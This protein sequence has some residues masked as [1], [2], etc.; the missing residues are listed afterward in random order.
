MGS[1]LRFVKYHGL[2][3]DFIVLERPE[4]PTPEEARRL[5]ARG[6]SIGAD[7]VMVASPPRVPGA[8]VAMDLVNSDGSSP[9]MCGNGIRCFVKYVVDRLG[10]R[11]N[12]CL[13][14]TPAGIRACAWTAGP[15]G[16]VASVRVEMGPARFAPVEI[17][18]AP[19][20]GAL[21]G[22]LLTLSLD[23]EA[24]TGTPVNTGNPHFVV[25]GSAARDLALRV[26]P[27]LEV[28]PAFPERANIEL[29]EVRS[30]E[31]VAVTVWERGCGLTW[32][33]GTGATAT[34]AAAVRRG[35]VPAGGRVRVTLPGGDLVITIAPDFSAAWMEGPATEVFVGELP[36]S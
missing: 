34:V 13:V 8:H 29:A 7:G 28:H 24:F 17:P 19:A 33:C 26:G 25:F 35:L 23:G 3:N 30:P 31:H 18:C 9:E 11:D 4:P 16:R 5:C 2:G 12:P 20:E 21:D 27:R 10:R 14:E 6:F 22:E 32:A 36:G 15:D 1:N